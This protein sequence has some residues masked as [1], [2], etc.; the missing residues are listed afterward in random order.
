MPVV[1]KVQYD[2]FSFSSRQIKL[3]YVIPVELFRKFKVS[4][5]YSSHRSF[6]LSVNSYTS[7]EV[8]LWDLW[9][10]F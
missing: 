6:N 8:R 10:D 7:G 4:W 1:D 9:I 5:C 3:S 2:K